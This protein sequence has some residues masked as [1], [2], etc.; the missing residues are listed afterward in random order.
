M[1]QPQP[2]NQN[3]QQQI[4]RLDRVQNGMN[5]YERITNEWNQSN[6]VQEMRSRRSSLI[7]NTS[8]YYTGNRVHHLRS[9]QMHDPVVW[10]QLFGHE[11]LNQSLREYAQASMNWVNDETNTLLFAG[12]MDVSLLMQMN[13]RPGV[14]VAILFIHLSPNRYFRDGHMVQF[15]FGEGSQRHQTLGRLFDTNEYA[16]VLQATEYQMLESLADDDEAMD[17]LHSCFLQPDF[18]SMR[19]TFV[20]PDPNDI[21]D[22]GF[23]VVD[24]NAI[25][26]HRW[27]YF[28]HAD[29]AANAAADGDHHDDDDHDNAGWNENHENRAAAPRP[30]PPINNFEE[31]YFAE[32]E[33]YD[34]E[35]GRRNEENDNNIIPYDSEDD[36]PEIEARG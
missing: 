29:D 5:E 8:G 6:A 33:N 16:V 4:D 23:Y 24:P 15:E 28:A 7:N 34:N 31:I 18:S 10:T 14:H 2:E 25:D 36:E 12:Q 1:A 3:Q 13:F 32:L 26:N 19:F 35:H 30:P 20:E 21:D 11:N 9:I 22:Q 17:L 27:H